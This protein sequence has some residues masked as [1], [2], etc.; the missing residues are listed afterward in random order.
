M[1]LCTRLCTLF[2]LSFTFVT[3]AFADEVG[4][5]DFRISDM[6]TNGVAGI[7]AMA[8]SI[9]YNSTDNEYIVI[10]VGDDNTAPLVVGEHEVFGQRLDGNGNEIGSDFR[11]SDMGPNG[12]VDYDVQGGTQKNQPTIVYNSTDNEYL[13]VWNGEDNTGSLIDGEPEIFGQRLDADG[14]EIGTNDF[15]I[16]TMG[17]DG[18]GNYFAS[19]GAHA[20][21]NSTNNEYL[22][23]WT[24]EDDTAPLVNNE[25]EVF[26]QRLDTDG[27]EIGTNDFRIS[28]MGTNGTTNHAPFGDPRVTYNNTDNEYLVVWSGD[29]N[30]GA[31]V[32]EAYEIFGQRLDTD[33]NEIGTNDFRISDMGELDTDTAFQAFYPNVTYN[34]TDNEYLVVWYGDDERDDVTDD[35]YE[36]YGQ[37]LDADGNEIGDNDFKI[38]DVG[39]DSSNNYLALSPNAYFNSLD[40]E[41]LVTWAAEDNNGGMVDEEYEIFGQR[42]NTNGDEIGDNDFRISD[43]GPDGDANYDATYTQSIAFNITLNQYLVVWSGDDNTGTLV[44]GE[45]EIFGQSLNF[46]NCGNGV[47]ETDESCDDGNDD[48]TDTCLNTCETASCGDGFTQTGAE[49]CDDGN[50]DNTDT[51]LNTCVAASC[52]DGFIQTGVEECDNAGANSDT[53]ANACRTTC[54]EA[55]CGDDIIDTGEECDDGNATNDDGC[56]SVCATEDADSGDDSTGSSSAGGCSLEQNSSPPS[57]NTIML[58][59]LVMGALHLATKRKAF[60]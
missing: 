46:P 36:I 48:N 9:A 31:L 18:D 52:G 24:G 32:Q 13:V 10:W 19:S 22:V 45:I 14:N 47:L 12:D 23:V 33:G 39:P 30:T 3:T 57:L 15:K 56:D 11:I 2:L 7:T 27:N 25:V 54:I 34:Q 42:L 5:N 38:S 16:S 51:C 50:D 29:D 28:D 37:L 8:P 21:Y 55:S 58:V 53:M 40:D 44:D 41:Y 17:P 4:T 59:I 6:G 20:S 35:E 26:G 1:K 43:M 60:K 49:E